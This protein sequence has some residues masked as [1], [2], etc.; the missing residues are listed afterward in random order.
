M[1]ESTFH[2]EEH[3]PTSGELN[4]LKFGEPVVGRTKYEDA[5]TPV[6]EQSVFPDEKPVEDFGVEDIVRG[7]HE[8]KAAQDELAVLKPA[9]AYALSK[10]ERKQLRIRREDMELIGQTYA[11][12]AKSDG[13][14]GIIL[15]SVKVL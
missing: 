1:L 14:G 5:S 2:G 3:E 11:L 9:F 10:L 13:Q 15:R 6:E 7:L 4:Y 8:G 12:Q